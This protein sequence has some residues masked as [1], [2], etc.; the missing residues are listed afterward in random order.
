MSNIAQ[1]VDRLA[2][3]QR[4]MKVLKQESGTIEADLLKL[5]ER[6]LENTKLKTVAYAGTAGNKVTATMSASM[7]IIYPSYLKR[8]FGDAYADAITEET[9]IK[10][11]APATRMLCGLWKGE[12]IRLTI[13]QAIDQITS[14]LAAREMLRKKVKGAAFAT[15]KKNIM[16]ICGVDEKSA[17][18]SAYLIAEAAI[19]ENFRRLMELQELPEE[20]EQQ[21]LSWIDGA[22]VVEET[23]K[24]T[25]EVGEDG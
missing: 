19:W 17:E 12:Y 6:D 8:I 14:D 4:E 3:I 24:I 1:K 20:Q 25:I 5:A 10:V 22:I 11:T 21:I 7:K 23:P 16:A 15:D 13:S 9:K 18:E 2:A